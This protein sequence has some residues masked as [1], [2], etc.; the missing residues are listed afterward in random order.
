MLRLILPLTYISVHKGEKRDNIFS[1]LLQEND[2]QCMFGML[3]YC[4]DRLYHAVRRHAKATG[5]WQW[6]V[7][8][9]VSFMIYVSTSSRSVS[10]LSLKNDELELG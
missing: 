8:S 9:S 1:A 10:S 4:L 2:A 3:I 7:H 5:E 6:L